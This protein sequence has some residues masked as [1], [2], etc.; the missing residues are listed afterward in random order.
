LI[1]A[2]LQVAA[3]LGK[4]VLVLIFMLVVILNNLPFASLGAAEVYD[5]RVS[6]AD[7]GVAI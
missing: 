7:T 2:P 5:P 1:E 3:I 6:A 4:N